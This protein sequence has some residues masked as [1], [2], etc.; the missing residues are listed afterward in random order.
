MVPVLLLQCEVIMFDKIILFIQNII[1]SIYNW[2]QETFE[3]F[4]Y[5]FRTNFDNIITSIQSLYFAI[6]EEIYIVLDTLTHYVGYIL[7]LRLYMP[8][9]TLVLG[10]WFIMISVRALSGC[11]SFI[12][13]F[14][15]FKFTK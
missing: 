15:P 7:P 6:P 3:G 11:L 1:S 2:Y 14:L 12:K 5:G 10:Y 8:I 9:I 13:T 4:F